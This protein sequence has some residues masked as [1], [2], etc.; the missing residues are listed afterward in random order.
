[1]NEGHQGWCPGCQQCHGLNTEALLQINLSKT[2]I[3][4][5]A[6]GN[7]LPGPGVIDDM[8]ICAIWRGKMTEQDQ[9]LKCVFVKEVFA[10]V[11]IHEFVCWILNRSNL[12][13]L[14]RM[15]HSK[16][17]S[18]FRLCAGSAIVSYVSNMLVNV[19]ERAILQCT[20]PCL[21]CYLGPN[22]W[23]T[24]QQSNL[25]CGMIHS[26]HIQDYCRR[27]VPPPNRNFQ[28]SVLMS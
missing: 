19:N 1:M 9:P 18:F 13:M 10:V 22:T 20:C 3:L 25:V 27:N 4:V 15:T 7:H 14:W 21:C 17:V 2:D 8:H 12:W 6:C 24:I 16:G 26:N 5:S 28:G 23:P 11:M